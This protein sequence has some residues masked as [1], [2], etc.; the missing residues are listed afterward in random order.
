MNGPLVSFIMPVFNGEAFVREAVD[1]C[2]SQTH[3]NIEVIVTDDGSTDRTLEILHE[4]Y[5]SDPRVKIFSLGRNKGKVAAYN[6]SY[7][8]AS[9][10]FV[11][12]LDADDISLQDRAEVSLKALQE[13]DAEMVCGDAI[14]FGETVSDKRRIA[15]DW[16][17]LKG[18]AAFDFDA[19]LKR[20]QI[21]GPTIMATRSVCEAIFPMDE[22]M[23]HQDWWMPLAAAYRKSVRYLDRPLIQY[24]IHEA[25]TSRVNP[26]Q[27]FE[28]WLNITTREI[29]YYEC[30][31]E[32]FELTPEQSEFC[33][34]RIQMFRLLQQKKVFTRLS[35]GF[36]HIGLALGRGVPLREKI[37]Y[38]MAMTSPKLSYL[39]S[40]ALA[41]SRR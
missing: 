12:V 16:F 31:L 34:C 21:L 18:P 32:R 1:S 36:S 37:K 6:H 25:N 2:L 23:S 3:K 38:W 17:G 27:D 7:K 11:A 39:A 35:E 13:L 30:V 40:M 8:N 4:A 9:G 5:D 24:R 15:C 14:K 33:L 19:L 41:R 22:R 10:D 28:R 29:F 26:N 20:P